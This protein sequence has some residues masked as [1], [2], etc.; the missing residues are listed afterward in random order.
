MR[1]V[2]A[3][4]LVLAACHRGEKVPDGDVLAAVHRPELKGKPGI[5]MFVTPTCPHCL[6]TIPHAIEAAAASQATV[7]AVFV[8]GTED[9]AK[10]VIEHTKFPGEWMVDDGALTRRY[11]IKSVPYILVI[12]RDGV[13]QDAFLGEQDTSTLKD[14]LAD[15]R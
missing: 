2:L 9:N 10:G 4:A 15:A 1:F 11:H 13:A 14:A 7:T 8:A 3:I 5:V 6:A 12:G